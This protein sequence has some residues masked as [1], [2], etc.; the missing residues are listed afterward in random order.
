MAVRHEAACVGI[1]VALLVTACGVEAQPAPEPVPPGRLP[2]ASPS[3]AAPSAASRG[4]VWGARDGRLV[5][6]FAELR[7]TGTES[8]VRA[9]LSL[10]D[11]DNRLPSALPPG[12]RLL[13]ITGSG[14]RIVLTL[15]EELRAVPPDDLPL[16][17]AQLV[18]TVTERPDVRRVHVRADQDPIVYVDATGRRIG[19]ALVRSD[20]AE[21]VQG[22]DAPY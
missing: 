5:P 21:L 17:L 18:F 13:R 7:G 19:R 10:A 12:T 11:P 9:V 8:R 15:S 6:V 22:A 2:A 16:A 3:T 14:D 4:Q 20:F 1:V